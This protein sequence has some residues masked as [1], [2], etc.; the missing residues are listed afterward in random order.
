MS[1]P[2]H[3]L[4]VLRDEPASRGE[5]AVVRAGNRVLDRA[6]RAADRAVVES[7]RLDLQVGIPAGST[8]LRAVTEPARW[9]FLSPQQRQY[10]VV[11]RLLVVRRGRTLSM[12]RE[13]ATPEAV[14]DRLV[15]GLAQEAM[16]QV[17]A[18]VVLALR[19]IA[20]KT[21]RTPREVGRRVMRL[22]KEHPNLLRDA[23]LTWEVLS[24]TLGV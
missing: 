23:D 13:T 14:P 18:A 17:R 3:I 6:A 10:L 20:D 12:L 21:D 8:A 19:T 22:A 5:S 16:R 7:Q 11:T 4:D 24:A 15:T 9:G 2:S 1:L